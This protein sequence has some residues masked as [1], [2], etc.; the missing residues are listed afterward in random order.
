MNNNR[1]Y[2][3][4]LTFAICGKRHHTRFYPT[5]QASSDRKGN[6]RP[7]TVVDVG[8]TA[9]YDT[10]FYLQAHAGLQGTTRPTHYTILYDEN[11][12]SAD[13]LQQGTNSASYMFARATRSVSLVPAAYYADLAAERGRQYLHRILAGSDERATTVASGSAGEEEVLK[14]AVALWKKGIHENLKD[15][16]FYI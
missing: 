12:L 10:D 14:E 7:G 3:P 2:R 16:M 1:P 5:D 15:S 4:K 8:V 11:H 6:P 13:T 9:V